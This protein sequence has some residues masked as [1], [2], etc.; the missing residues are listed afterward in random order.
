MKVKMKMVAET[1]GPM[2]NS[3]LSLDLYH[4]HGIGKESCRGWIDFNNK[5]IKIPYRGIYE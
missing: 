1:D 5:F 4:F 2:D 3:E